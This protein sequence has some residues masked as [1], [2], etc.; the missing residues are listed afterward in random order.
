M[1]INE[2]YMRLVPRFATLQ[3]NKKK[4][5]FIIFVLFTK[6]RR[7]DGDVGQ[8]HMVHYWFAC[9]SNYEPEFIYLR[10]TRRSVSGLFVS[11]VDKSKLNNNEVNKSFVIWWCSNFH[12]LW[13]ITRRA[14]AF[15]IDSI[16]L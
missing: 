7:I 1:K 9:E 2:R 5:F 13:S 3:P 16:W 10:H 6:K 11:I 15:T 14:E 4:Y 12:L 8:R